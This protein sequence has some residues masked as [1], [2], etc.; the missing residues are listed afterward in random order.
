MSTIG[1][2]RALKNARMCGMSFSSLAQRNAQTERYATDDAALGVEDSEG[3]RVL[4][5]V[6]AIA[7]A[8]INGVSVFSIYNKGKIDDLRG[9][10]FST[11]SAKVRPRVGALKTKRFSQLISKISGQRNGRLEQRA[12]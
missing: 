6:R 12:E 5:A 1:F 2:L 9:T 3:A 7:P 4:S 10:G 11:A 8:R